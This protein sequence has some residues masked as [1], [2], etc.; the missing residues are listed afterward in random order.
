M[1]VHLFTAPGRRMHDSE[2]VVTD[3]G[4]ADVMK[5][6]CQH[7]EGAVNLE[8]AWKPGDAGGGSRLCPTPSQ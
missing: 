3:V 8:L 2:S 1:A 5:G 7:S 6:L 4:C